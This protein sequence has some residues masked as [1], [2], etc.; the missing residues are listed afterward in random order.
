MNRLAPSIA[1]SGL[2][3]L[4]SLGPALAPDSV[5]AWRQRKN[6]RA[7]GAR[8]LAKAA[9]AK[10]VFERVFPLFE[11]VGLHVLPIHFYTPVPDTRQLRKHRSRWDREW[12]LA[13]IDLSAE[14]QRNWMNYLTSFKHEFESLDTE[15]KVAALGFGEG[16]GEVESR[17]LHAMLRSLKPRNVIE[18]GA[19]VSTFFAANALTMNSNETGITPAII[20]VEPHPYRPLRKLQDLFPAVCFELITQPVQDLP[21]SLF[22][23]LGQGDV[24]FIDSSHVSKLDSDVDR[25]YLEVLPSLRHGVIIHIDD[26]PFPWLARRPDHWIFKKH[27]FWNEA[28]LLNAFL[29][30][31]ESFQVLFSLSYLHCRQPEPLQE[32]VSY[33]TALFHP[34]SI[35]LQRVR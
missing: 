3:R 30:F 20:S 27:R 15:A 35:W 21:I 18:V 12:S 26:I 11:H 29:S 2:R 24:L 13:G 14:R 7:M 34:S 4:P 17:V 23:K 10:L 5:R 33:D 6:L 19:G 31:N 22:S 32:L 8:E 25:L 16:Y 28:T 1:R 9:W